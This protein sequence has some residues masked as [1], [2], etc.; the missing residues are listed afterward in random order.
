MNFSFY[1]LRPGTISIFIRQSTCWGFEFDHTAISWAA[2]FA[3]IMFCPV[4]S[5]LE[6]PTTI[7]SIDWISA[8]WIFSEF[9]TISTALCGRILVLSQVDVVVSDNKFVTIWTASNIIQ[10]VFFQ[11]PREFH[12][13]STSWLNK[14]E[15][16]WNTTI[17]S[18]ILNASFAMTSLKT[19][20]KIKIDIMPGYEG[21]T[22]FEV[23]S[24]EVGI[25]LVEP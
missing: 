24:L 10:V 22:V 2:I 11:F 16:S 12:Q 19:G 25:V 8:A 1:T 7:S 13:V 18:K 3:T 5:I 21:Q 4:I 23:C 9:F 20:S 14:D 17:L 6:Y 15:V